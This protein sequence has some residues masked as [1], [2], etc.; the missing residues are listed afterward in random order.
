MDKV[1]TLEL[2]SSVKDNYRGFS[3]PFEPFREDLVPFVIQEYARGI[4]CRFVSELG[5]YLTHQ[6]KRII[7]TISPWLEGSNIP[8]VG[9]DPCFGNIYRAMHS[10]NFEHH[11]TIFAAL[12]IH[13]SSFG[14]QGTWEVEL[15]S[16]VRLRWGNLLLP[17]ASHVSVDCK[18][19]VAFIETRLS[20]TN[21]STFNIRKIGTDWVC[22]GLDVIP[23]QTNYQTDIAM[24]PKSAL[25]MPDL[26]EFVSKAVG[27]I[28]APIVK[29]FDDSLDLINKHVP[30]YIPWI[31]RSVHNVFLLEKGDH[32]IDSG[33]VEHYLGLVHFS[34]YP[35]SLIIAE[36]LVHEASH[37]HMNILLKLGAVDDG[38][39]RNL[40]YSPPVDKNRT[41][42][43]ILAAYHAFANVLIFYR[44]CRDTGVSDKRECDRQ[45]KLLL[46]WLSQL[47][48]P[49]I[50]NSA[51]TAIGNALWQPLYERLH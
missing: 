1:S 12:A 45:E 46:P 15:S 27:I 37:Q 48:K 26:E 4:S 36:L 11:A 39:D 21:Q 3:C 33:S 9:W 24:L 51:L 20:S 19:E 18:E 40:Y 35:V 8:G 34:S 42:H 16:P 29:V 25:F 22:E 28:D 50:Q 38:S 43:L 5:K 7:E 31:R 23:K 49:L 17:I 44:T 6:D 32:M 2:P 47:E 41:L 13:L 14:L 10:D 30:E